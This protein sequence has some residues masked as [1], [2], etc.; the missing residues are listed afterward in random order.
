MVLRSIAARDLSEPV[1]E[2]PGLPWLIY[3]EYT[4]LIGQATKLQ[5]KITRP[6]FSL[7]FRPLETP[8]PL[9]ETSSAP[10]CLSQSAQ[11][12]LPM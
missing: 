4:P 3:S 6:L 1:P 12:S 7:H 9:L 10:H 11:L 8:F 5:F 2:A